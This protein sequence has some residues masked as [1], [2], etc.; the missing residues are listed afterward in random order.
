MSEA[1]LNSQG[2]SRGNKS[3]MSS[4]V[5]DEG[6]T[7]VSVDL[8]SGEP[9]VTSHYSKDA[10]Y[11]YANFTGIG[12]APFYKDKV[13]MLDDQYLMGASVSPTGREPMREAFN[14][15]WGGNTFAEQWLENKKVITKDAS[16]SPIRASHK[17]QILAMQYGQGPKGMILDA[18]SKG[19]K[20]QLDHA[21]GFHRAF[22]NDLF[23]GVRDLGKRLTLQNKKQGFI[24]NEFGFR[25]F[26]ALY[27]SLNYFIQS[28]VSGI[29][30]ILMINFY[31]LAPYCNHLAIIHDEL[32]FSCPDDRLVEAREAMDKALEALNNTLGW[33]VNIRTGWVEGKDFYEAH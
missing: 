10:R 2:M 3:L 26:P 23:P 28:S 15:T 24:V 9:S 33:S 30:D 11:T 27:K 25:L 22:W 20:L 16:I 18:E 31:T 21:K 4:I 19:L 32:I 8:T 29:V 13:L 5:S 14:S 12:K 7:F 1:K 6:T 17:G